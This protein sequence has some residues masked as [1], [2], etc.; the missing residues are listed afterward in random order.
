MSH[1]VSSKKYLLWTLH[2]AVSSLGKKPAVPSFQLGSDT[3]TVLPKDKTVNSDARQTG[4]F[5]ARK[6]TGTNYTS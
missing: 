6:E 2:P 3:D 1:V 5:Q 4:Y